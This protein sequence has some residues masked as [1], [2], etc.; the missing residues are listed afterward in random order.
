[1]RLRDALEIQRGDVVAFIGAGGKTSALFR[2]GYELHEEGWRVLATT[3]TRLARQEM[4][5]APF[6]ARLTPQIKPDMIHEWLNEHGFVFLYSREDK[7]RGKIIGLHP[8]VIPGLMDS[9]NSDVLLIEADG[10]RRLPFKAPYAHEPVIP[11]DTSLVVP[12]A[13]IDVLGQ[14]LDEDHVYNAAAIM[15]R[16][17]FP[18]GGSMLPPWMAVTIRDPELGL[19]GV[20]DKARVVVLLNKVPINGYGRARA[21]RVAQLVLRS[22]RVEGV[23]LGAMREPGE[24]VHEAQHRVAAVVLAA[25]IS[26]RMGQSK[27]L[28]PWDERT[29][30]EVI[31]S[32][33]IAVRVSDI[34]VVTG[35]RSNDVARALADKPVQIVYNP[36]YLQGEMLSSLQAGLRTLDASTS[37]CLVVLGDQPTL[38][39]RVINRVMAAY[40]EG[41]GDIVVPTY[42]GKRGHPVLIG[43]HFW[44]ELLALESGAPRDVIRRHPDD[45]A[46]LDLDTDS[47]LRDIDTPEQYHRERRLAGLR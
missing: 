36:N 16:Y 9:V 45:L 19:R 20:P 47:I 23:V 31:V 1:M 32:R 2:L 30:I 14:P 21:R 27:A 38:E 22:P 33:L 44:P 17:G 34:V 29:V 11:P 39:T 25:G 26:S 7:K 28:L 35:H 5:Y 46:L 40:A 37:A 10:S 6:A 24:P 12:V 41:K 8:D 13:G 4:V 3:T 42:R 15:E 43:Q 18:E